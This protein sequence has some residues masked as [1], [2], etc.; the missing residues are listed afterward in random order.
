MEDDFLIVPSGSPDSYCRLCLS[1]NNVEALLVADGFPQPNQMLVDLIRR[2][3]EIGLSAPVDSPCGI[4]NTC[5]MMLEEFE[6][7]RERCLRC[8]Y[9]LTG[10]ERQHGQVLP[11][12]CSQCPSKFRFKT[13]FEKHWKSLHDLYYHCDVCDAA[14]STQSMLNGHSKFHEGIGEQNGEVELH[15]CSY[16]PRIFSND[17]QL[18]FHIQVLHEPKASNDYVPPAR[19]KKDDKPKATSSEA[20]PAVVSI[21]IMNSEPESETSNKPYECKTCR[22]R[23]H[24]IGSLTRHINDKH[25]QHKQKAANRRKR[26]SNAI[27]AA[28]VLVNESIVVVDEPVPAPVM[29]EITDHAIATPDPVIAIPDLGSSILDPAIPLIADMAMP[30]TSAEV[31][32]ETY[33]QF[34]IPNEPEYVPE[35]IPASKAEHIEYMAYSEQEQIPAVYPCFVLMERLDENLIPPIP[36]SE[37]P[38]G[39]YYHALQM[40]YATTEDPIDDEFWKNYPTY[41]S[42]ICKQFRC[43]IC[44]T[45]LSTK[46]ALYRHKQY[47]H[48]PNVYQCTYCDKVF[49]DKAGIDR[50]MPLHTND[51]P[52]VCDECPLGFTRIG[53]LNK[54]KQKY[55]GPGALPQKLHYCPYCLRAF[56][57]LYLIKNHVALEHQDQY[58]VEA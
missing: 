43:D 41:T 34:Q 24:F 52:H 8:D 58:E 44:F 37:I 39:K 57:K 14:F 16:C 42:K 19:K 9:A 1:E 33:G 20:Q 45:E 49:P 26:K 31:V 18:R 7:F 48:N 2:H 27:S 5:R 15:N 10:I 3:M 36:N 40:Q 32:S 47:K 28:P 22:V 11:F 23:F 25:A 46:M 17:K 35:L 38:L 6:R 30:R 53:L 12:E 54:H 21:N 55:H 13:E 4:C 56:N 29:V 51:Y 50:H